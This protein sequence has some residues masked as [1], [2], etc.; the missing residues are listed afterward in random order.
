M[1]HEIG[2]GEEKRTHEERVVIIVPDRLWNVV[3]EKYVNKRIMNIEIKLIEGE[4]WKDGNSI[5]RK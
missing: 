5:W 4:V 3:I 1:F 2:G